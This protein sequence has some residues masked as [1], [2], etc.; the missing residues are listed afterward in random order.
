MKAHSVLVVDDEA[1]VRS[2]YLDALSEAGHAVSV[3]GTSVRI[4]RA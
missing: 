2:L 4:V 1:N 3:E